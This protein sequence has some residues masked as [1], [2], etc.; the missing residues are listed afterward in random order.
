MCGSAPPAPKVAP[1]PPAPVPKASPAA[2]Q[3]KIAKRQ[4]DKQT[5]NLK[6]GASTRLTGPQGLMTAVNTGTSTLLGTG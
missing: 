1:L 2:E 4:Q 3:V 5:R 6:G